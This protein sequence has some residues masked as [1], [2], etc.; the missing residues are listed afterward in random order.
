MTNPEIIIGTCPSKSNSYRI[1]KHG[2]HLAMAKKKALTDYEKS[3]FIQCRN[4]GA[5]IKGYFEF[6]VNVYYP[7]ERADLDNSL[8][9]LLDCL[10]HCKVIPN[11]NRCIKIVAQKFKDVTRPRVEFEIVKVLP[12]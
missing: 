3:F 11:D 9:I 2:Q 1:V 7:S 6:H 12:E 5:M 10:Q 8:K 4:R